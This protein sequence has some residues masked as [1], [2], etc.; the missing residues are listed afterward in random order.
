M[1]K[2]PASYS[3]DGTQSSGLRSVPLVAISTANE[4]QRVS[5]FADSPYFSR[6]PGAEHELR[7]CI[8]DLLYLY[9]DL[10]TRTSRVL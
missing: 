5:E 2:D 9:R 10:S 3:D 7:P 6:P 8:R 4:L 1:L